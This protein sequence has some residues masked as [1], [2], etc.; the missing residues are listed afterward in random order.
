M[1]AGWA[2]GGRGAG[3]RFA[4]HLQPDQ[5]SCP[6]PSVR[7]AGRFSRST[8][9]VWISTPPLTRFFRLIASAPLLRLSN[10]IFSGYSPPTSLRRLS[11]PIFSGYSP[12]T[13]LRRPANPIFSGCSPPTP[14]RRPANPIFSGCSRQPCSD[15][16]LT[17][18]LRVTAR[19]PCSDG[20]LTRFFRLIASAPPLRPP[21]YSGFPRNSDVG[22][23]V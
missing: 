16:S 4:C 14:L 18:F 21:A 5:A 8:P 1:G 11:N 13:L 20:P 9:P 3:S 22:T 2:R 12:P 6:S 10:P 19:Q 23:P 17:R 7:T 15:V